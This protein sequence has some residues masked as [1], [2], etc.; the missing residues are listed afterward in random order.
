ME[1][2]EETGAPIDLDQFAS[3]L[4]RRDHALV[5]D[6]ADVTVDY[7]PLDSGAMELL[8]L[9]TR[10][11]RTL[12]TSRYNQRVA[13]CADAHRALRKV[14]EY[15]WL[16]QYT[17]EDLARAPGLAGDP[18]LR[19]THVVEEMAR[20]RAAITA[21][22]GQDLVGLGRL[23]NLSHASSRDLYEVSCAELDV[24]TGAARECEDVFGARLTGAGFGGCAVAI[25]RPGSAGRVRSLV[26][27]RFKAEFGSPPGF[28]L[29]RPGRGPVERGLA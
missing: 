6:C 16:A 11:P 3:A 13:E 17:A 29:L 22:R 5:L 10:V 15:E 2:L 19:V 4:G 8:V 1:Y 18:R 21:L 25:L 28:H 24:I 9:D 27:A 23:L 26:E 7:V 12:A 20:V 14:R